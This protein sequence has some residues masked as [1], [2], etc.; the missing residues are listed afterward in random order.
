M[1][2]TAAR[3]TLSDISRAARAAREQGAT[4]VEVLPDGTIRIVIS[5]GRHS[6]E[7][8]PDAQEPKY[9]DFKL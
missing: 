9:R 8:A 6:G 7:T 4:A 2:K 3:F 1:S 5:E